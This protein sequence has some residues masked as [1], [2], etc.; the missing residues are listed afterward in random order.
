MLTRF[1]LDTN[2]VECAQP[3]ECRQECDTDHVKMLACVHRMIIIVDGTEQT[4]TVADRVVHSIA[5]PSPWLRLVLVFYCHKPPQRQTC[6]CTATSVRQPACTCARTHALS[7]SVSAEVISFPNP[8][9]CT[10]SLYVMA[11]CLFV[12]ASKKNRLSAIESCAWEEDMV[13]S[14]HMNY[15]TE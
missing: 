1:M 9:S 13:L 14:V 12:V 7:T 8:Y 3:V 6:Q 2:S 5:V 4:R 15:E 11:P 10:T